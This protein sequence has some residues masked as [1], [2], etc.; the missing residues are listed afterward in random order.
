MIGLAA[1]P[2]PAKVLDMR[3]LIPK[4]ISRASLRLLAAGLIG[5]FIGG[6]VWRKCLKDDRVVV[7]D[8]VSGADFE[9]TSVDGTPVQRRENL[10]VITRVPHA[11]I[12]PGRRKLTV[13]ARASSPRS[14]DGTGEESTIEAQILNGFRYRLERD[15]GGQPCLAVIA[16]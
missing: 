12:E 2:S 5:G 15:E 14:P 4:F 11:L 13:A 7:E 3:R 16:H 1:F 6:L 10:G 8:Y 9:I